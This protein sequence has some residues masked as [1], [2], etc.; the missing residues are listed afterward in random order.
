MTKK[1]KKD[2]QMAIIATDIKYIKAAIDEIKDAYVTQAE[3]RP[4]K[5]IVYGLVGIVLVGVVTALL[6]SVI[7]CTGIRCG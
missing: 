2:V 1:D 7:R 3:F 4:V 5:T 6:Y